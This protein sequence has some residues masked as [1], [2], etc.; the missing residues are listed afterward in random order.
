MFATRFALRVRHPCASPRQLACAHSVCAACAAAAGGPPCPFNY[1]ALEML[2]LAVKLRAWTPTDASGVFR[3]LEPA[4]APSTQLVDA[5]LPARSPSRRA[6]LMAWLPLAMRGLIPVRKSATSRPHAHASGGEEEVRATFPSPYVCTALQRH[7][8]MVFSPFP[9]RT[10]AASN[11]ARC[12]T[13]SLQHG[14]RLPSWS[15]VYEH[16]ANLEVVWT[17][18]WKFLPQLEQNS[19]QC[20]IVARWRTSIQPAVRVLS[21]QAVA[22][23]VRR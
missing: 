10:A 9:P 8:A 3:V 23:C 5:A 11:R 20:G 21:A 12:S 17:A 7:D 19:S 13:A 4:P 16:L 1:P 2:P 22:H 18:V 6:D 15:A 14:M